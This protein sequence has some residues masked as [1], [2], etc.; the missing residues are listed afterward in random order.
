VALLLGTRIEFQIVDM[1][2]LLLGAIPFS[3]YV[4][5]PVTQLLEIVE[6]AEPRVLITEA[7]LA[8][9]A[10]DLAAAYPAIEHVVVIEDDAAAVGELSLAALMA[11]CSPDFDI[12][13]GA[14]CAN[15]ED[16]CTLVYTSG[17]TGSPKGVQIEHRMVLACLDSIQQRF[18]TSEHDRALCYLPMA[19][20][21]ERIFGH[22][23]AFVY[24]YEVICV[25]T[26]PQLAEAL[27]AV[28]PTRFFG[29]PR[30]YEKL[31]AGV[32]RAIETSPVRDQA[33]EAL[34]RRL[35]RVRAEQ[36]GDPVPTEDL[37]DADLATLQPFAALTGLDQAHFVAVAGAPSS[38][39]VLEETTAL[40]IPVNEFYGSSEVSIVTCSPTD[41][42]RLGTAGMPL[43]GVQLQL[44]QDSEVLIA[45]PT[46]SSGYFRD[47]TR[48]AEVFEPDGWFHTG[49][50]GEVGEDGYVR[51]IDRKKELIINSF[52]KNMSPANIEQAV[53]GGHPFIAQVFAFGDRRPYNVALVV[54]DREGLSAL[55]HSLGQPTGEF[56]NMARR[57]EVL[58][59]VA[60]AVDLGNARLSR[61]EQI[62]KHHVLDHEWLPGTDELT[63]TS[64][65]RRRVVAATYTT[66]IDALYAE[67]SS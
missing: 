31:L 43:P 23:A 6:N 51:I 61:V 26:L 28:R 66:Q 10:R 8:D 22:Y 57:P 63:P 33:R 39:D 16:L 41:R 13:A 59:A 47:P 56:A 62:K 25:P 7:A 9:K 60:N 18:D 17:T 21:A 55:V 30:I 14:H 38:L 34:C 15:G 27:Q 37:D 19:H 52:G 29:V 40:G 42:I 24:G 48:T 2:A 49:D 65:L 11:A 67:E 64:K 58:H 4:T 45:G 54:L 50:I 20:I 12:M 36:A 1:G 35:D 5:S 46:V 53:K 32:H 44:G 3:L